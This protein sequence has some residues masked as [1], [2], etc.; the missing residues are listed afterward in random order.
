MAENGLISLASRHSAP[1]TMQRLLGALSARDMTVFAR[2]DH[3]ANAAAAGMALRP[4]E[5]CCS[6][7]PVAAPR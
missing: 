4:T 5:W 2:V 6:A 1:E 7:I 3:A